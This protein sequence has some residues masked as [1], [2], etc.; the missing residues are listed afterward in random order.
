MSTPSLPPATQT[1][2]EEMPDIELPK[3]DPP[4][5]PH[6]FPQTSNIATLT[7]ILSFLEIP[8]LINVT[9]VNRY[10][11][12]FIIDTNTRKRILSWEL[13]RE[14]ESRVNNYILSMLAQS[15][16]VQNNN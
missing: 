11:Y 1:P 3:I 4:H 16:E 12:H 15:E 6:L 8:D 5:I 14:E 13:P 7:N 2:T 10:A 9:K